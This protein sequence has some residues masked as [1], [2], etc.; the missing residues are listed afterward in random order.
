M[1][2]TRSGG[3]CSQRGVYPIGKAQPARTVKLVSK[4]KSTKPLAVPAAVRV[5][6]QGKRGENDKDK[7]R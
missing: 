6:A 7:R 2:Q 1:D 4:G 5:D 3:L